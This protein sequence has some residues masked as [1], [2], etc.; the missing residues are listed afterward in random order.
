MGVEDVG[1][2]KGEG[3]KIFIRLVGRVVRVEV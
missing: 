3:I 1:R 2:G